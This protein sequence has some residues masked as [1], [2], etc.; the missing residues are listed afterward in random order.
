[1]RN[2]RKICLLF[3]VIF[4]VTIVHAQTYRLEA[5][6]VSPKQYGDGFSTTY[7]NGIRLGATAEFNLKHNFSLLTGALYSV[8]YSN[9]VQNYSA[10][11][12]VIYKTF[13]HFLDVPLRLTYTLPI[14]KNLKVFA[15]A[16]PN[17]NIGLAQPQK[18][19]ADL[20]DAWSAYTGI[21]SV[22]YGDNDLYKNALIS[23]INFQ[24]GVGGGVQWKNYQLKGGYDF[25]INSIN[26]IDT[27]KILHQSGWYVSLVYQF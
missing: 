9:K 1:M 17:L 16:G 12:S 4:A 20:S 24:M 6:F 19:Q 8:V 7:F 3:A 22:N 21:Q 23:R 13:G 2:F 10:S 14:A 11:D 26:K 27:S 5:G 18:I 15:F 25:G